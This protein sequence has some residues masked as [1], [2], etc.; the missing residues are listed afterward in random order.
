VK[1]AGIYVKAGPTDKNAKTLRELKAVA[2]RSER[3]IVEIYKD[4]AARNLPSQV[5]EFRYNTGLSG[6]TLLYRAR[7]KIGENGRKPV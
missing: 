2:A 1:R 3:E 6:T 4:A 7:R 5:T